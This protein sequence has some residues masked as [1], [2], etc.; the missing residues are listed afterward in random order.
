[1]E[2]VRKAASLESA[3]GRLI[4]MEVPAGASVFL[5]KQENRLAAV[6]SQI[7]IGA[8]KTLG[9]LDDNDIIILDPFASGHHAEIFQATAV[10]CL[11]GI[12]AA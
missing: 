6:G 8:G 3:A 4:L 11:S 10:P 1:M 5:G 12:L 7:P 9:R 2:D